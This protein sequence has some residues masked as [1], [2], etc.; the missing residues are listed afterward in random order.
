MALPHWLA[1]LVVFY[2]GVVVEITRRA[3]QPT[4]RNCL[5]RHGC[6]KR[7]L[8]LYC[9]L[10]QELGTAVRLLGHHWQDEM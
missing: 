9:Y 5:F 6:P 8:E 2:V 10:P 3:L 7:R 1:A 4:C